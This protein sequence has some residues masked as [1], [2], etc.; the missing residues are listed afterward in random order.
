MGAILIGIVK[1]VVLVWTAV[2]ASVSVGSAYTSWTM[3]VLRPKEVVAIVLWALPA[4]LIPVAGKVA[5]IIAVLSL[6][7][8][9]LGYMPN[10]PALTPMEQ[11]G[12][13]VQPNHWAKNITAIVFAAYF[14][15]QAKGMLFAPGHYLW[16]MIR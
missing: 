10:P 1:A 12:P 13:D 8:L 3:K 11:A 9:V 2:F 6:W 15:L 4:L 5:W 7:P 16:A 14:A